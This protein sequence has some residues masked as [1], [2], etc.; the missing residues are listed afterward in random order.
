MKMNI[1]EKV[2][3]VPINILL[4]SANVVVV[5]MYLFDAFNLQITDVADYLAIA[6]SFLFIIDV[7]I[8]RKYSQKTSLKAALKNMELRDIV[9]VVIYLLCACAVFIVSVFKRDTALG[10]ALHIIIGNIEYILVSVCI[11]LWYYKIKKRN[12]GQRQ[13]YS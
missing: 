2:I 7:I 9:F 10:S 11:G 5:F 3:I 8:L 12:K 13:N 1:I 4:M 6:L